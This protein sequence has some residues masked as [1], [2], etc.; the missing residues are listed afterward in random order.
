MAFGELNESPGKFAL[1]PGKTDKSLMYQH[2]M[3]DDVNAL[4]PPADSKLSLNSYEKRLIKKWIEQG[5]KFEKHWAFLP[6]KKKEISKTKVSN[7]VQNEIDDFILKKLQENNIQPSEKASKE[8]LIRRISLD[9]TG[10]PPQL[11]QAQELLAL[12]SE[13]IITRAIDRFL[14]TPAYG[15]RMTQSW[16]DVA[17]YADSHGYQD[18]SYRSMWPWRD[19]VIHAFNKNLPYDEFLTWQLAGDLLPN[20]NKEQILATGF[21][22]NHPITQEGG[23]I[24]EEYRTN[25]VLD[26]TNTL[27]KGILAL[28]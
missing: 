11:E 28:R 20:A 7:F 10:L 21:N 22:R 13:E 6:P 17:R 16:L 5:A 27:G 2:I 19:W 18:D 14:S 26:R 4:M 24:Q 25:Y 9:L 3:T 23:V 15:E 12:P 8:T 1:V